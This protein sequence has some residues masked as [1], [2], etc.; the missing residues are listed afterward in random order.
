MCFALR[1]LATTNQLGDASTFCST[2]AVFSFRGG[3]PRL[4][5]TV[6]SYNQ[7]VLRCHHIRQQR[8]LRSI[9][10]YEDDSGGFQPI[11]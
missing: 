6:I 2:C 5:T 9:K 7:C 1:G 11:R 3:D 4:S 10:D 8:V